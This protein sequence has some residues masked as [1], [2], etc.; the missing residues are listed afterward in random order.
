MNKLNKKFI[1]TIATIVGFTLLIIVFVAIFRACNKKTNNYSSAE[2]KMVSAAKKYYKKNQDKKP[3]LS[4]HTSVSVSELVEGNFMKPLSEILIDSSCTGEVIV[5]N[6]GGKYQIIPDLNCAEYK[7][8]HF[9]DKVIEENLVSSSTDEEPELDNDTENSNDENIS[10]DYL[11]GLYY[12]DGVYVFKGKDPNNY[13]KFA[14]TMWRIL[15]IDSN[16]I[17]RLIKNEAETKQLRWDTKF[18]SDVN[19]SYGINDYKNSLILEELTKVYDKLKDETKVHFAPFDVCIG[20][21]DSKDLSIDRNVDC[22]TVLEK[23]YI[24]V[25]SISDFARAS[26]DENCNSVISGSCRN[27]NYL[28]KVASQTWTTTA[29]SNNTYKVA[30]ISSGTATSIEARN[31]ATYNR[32][33]AINGK[34]LF[35]S[36]T[37]TSSDPYIINT[38]K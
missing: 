6:N 11:S 36:G 17:V 8:I 25:I 21:R 18:N 26:L 3:E 10:R 16:G 19:R 37:G 33:I 2:K 20:K 29:L 31:S 34:E 9:A 28:Y 30:Y 24:S 4:E 12:I 38:S 5:Y 23:Q 15:D 35:N 7:T 27:Y 14:K 13:V 32:V 1:I 22:A